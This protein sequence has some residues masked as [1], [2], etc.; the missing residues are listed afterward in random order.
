MWVDIPKIKLENKYVIV[1]NLMFKYGKYI[2][3]I[4]ENKK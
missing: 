4:S 2:Y 3:R 1:I